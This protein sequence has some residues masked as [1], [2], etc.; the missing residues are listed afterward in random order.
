M[1]IP[2]HGLMGFPMKI[3][4]RCGNFFL[5]QRA[6]NL[7]KWAQKWCPVLI[8][9][10]CL[11]FLSIQKKPWRVPGKAWKQKMDTPSLNIDWPSLTL[12]VI[13]TSI[14]EKTR[15]ATTLI[16]RAYPSDLECHPQL[17]LAAR[18]TEVRARFQTEGAEVKRVSWRP[19]PLRESTALPGVSCWVPRISPR[20]RL[21]AIWFRLW[22][23]L[24]SHMT[25]STMV[26]LISHEYSTWLILSLSLSI[27][28]Q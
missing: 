26:S 27:F 13:S 10:K 16:V 8:D 25:V 1:R 14:Q 4:Q 12:I 9:K 15:D 6:Q 22:K 24:K 17:L 5:T 2:R 19:K 21:E 20:Q 7:Q 23:E 28:L 18:S 11:F 3:E